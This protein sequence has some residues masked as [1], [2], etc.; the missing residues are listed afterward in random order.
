MRKKKPE[1][2]DVEEGS[3]AKEQSS[4][5]S[6]AGRLTPL[7]IQQIEFRRSFKGYDEREVDEFLDRL[8]EDFAA[9]L[10]EAQRLR[11]RAEGGLGAVITGG[12]AAGS[13]RSADEIVQR[14]RDDAARIVRE[15]QERATAIGAAALGPRAAGG[16]GSAPSSDDRA[17]IAPFIAKEREFLTSLATLVQGH[18]EAVRGMASSARRA[19]E[20]APT[21]AA[22][23]EQGE[24]RP[25]KPGTRPDSRPGAARGSAKQPEKR[26]PEPRKAPAAKPGQPTTPTTPATPA[27][28][29]ART[30][31][32]QMPSASP[33]PS[34]ERPPREPEEGA[35]PAGPS[36]RS[37]ASGGPTAPTPPGE[38]HVTIPEP[39]P[40]RAKRGDR[41][42]AEGDPSLRELFWGEE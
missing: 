37:S 26:T 2:S 13:K 34:T 41:K 9:A 7:D 40:A 25:P 15:A 42:L 16:E 19:G 4:S 36:E 33:T 39:D 28:P 10:D 23:A 20:A 31:P 14:A 35:R 3:V 38:G 24:R 29:P 1:S 5:P 32:T 6:R 18:A 17:S 21:V 8:T 11:D 27:T 22:S 12:T 30:P